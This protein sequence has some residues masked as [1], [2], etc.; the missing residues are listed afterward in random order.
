MSE[1]NSKRTKRRRNN[2]AYIFE[3]IVCLIALTAIFIATAMI[4]KYHSVE[5]EK[6]QLQS[7]LAIYQDP[8]NPY[9]TVS[10][11][12]QE[13][14]SARA[15]GV[16]AGQS[17]AKEELLEE[18]K[19]TLQDTD[20]SLETFKKYFPNDVIV[21]D[22][23]EYLFFPIDN[24]LEKT[25]IITS[26]YTKNDSGKISYIGTK[27]ISVGIDVSKFQDKIN[28][29]KVSEDNVDFAIIR[30]GYRGYSKGE[31]FD[32]E[33]FETNIK[34]ATKNGID[35][36]VY[37]LTQATSEDEA[38]EEAK[39]VLDQIEPY[40]ISYPV[41]LDIEAVGGNE[42]RG[43]ALT[44]EDRTKYAIAFLETIKKAGYDVCIYG[45]LKT[46]MLMLDLEQLEEYPK[47]F[48][49]YT[50]V[51]YY[52]YKYDCWQY[53]DSGSISGISEKVDL[54]IYFK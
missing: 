46:F 15:E 41:V 50:D 8:Q 52:P 51:P 14:E 26:D 13:A 2:I 40:K 10:E 17:G 37:F 23:G 18:I 4:F 27:N 53:T 11:A 21:V 1:T 16:I 43:N 29:T 5:L 49:G 35:V 33:K 36:G 9:M 44:A 42:G 7:E 47:W 34:G 3:I 19:T 25:D 24:N 12:K 48:A 6:E 31:I 32:D 45:N 22:S 28:W 54:N 20:S 39:Y 30:V 38:I